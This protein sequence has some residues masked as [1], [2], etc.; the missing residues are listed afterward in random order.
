M[1]EWH[2]S[3]FL[4]SIGLPLAA[5]PQP[6]VIVAC[7]PS[8]HA[9]T[10]CIGIAPS[11]SRRTSR[12]T[13]LHQRN[14]PIIPNCQAQIIGDRRVDPTLGVAVM[15]RTINATAYALALTDAIVAT[16]LSGDLEKSICR[17]KRRA[18]LESN[19]VR[20]FQIRA[21]V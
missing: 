11:A 19:L 9:G 17:D 10:V 4:H 18:P 14:E 8:A 2:H 3:P 1:K 20:R 13:R 16:G 5:M 7:W 6:H 15:S 21:G 12:L